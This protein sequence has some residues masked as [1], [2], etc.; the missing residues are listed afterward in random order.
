MSR[1]GNQNSAQ[2]L[3]NLYNETPDG[4]HISSKLMQ[5]G[6]LT[7]K[8]G[9]APNKLGPF[10]QLRVDRSKSMISKILTKAVGPDNAK[11]ILARVIT[12]GKPISKVAL[13]NILS[14]ASV[15]E[16]LESRNDMDNGSRGRDGIGKRTGSEHATS[17]DIERLKNDEHVGNVTTEDNWFP[18][19]G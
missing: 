2:V 13:G 17:E 4:G 19:E 9:S 14:D 15:K 5:G 11:S 16:Q 10:D 6:K 8:Q 7:G 1:V 12:S 3:Q 18:G